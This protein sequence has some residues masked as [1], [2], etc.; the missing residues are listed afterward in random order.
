MSRGGEPEERRRDPDP[1]RREPLFAYA[2]KLAISS[3]FGTR[4]LRIDGVRDVAVEEADVV[5]HDLVEAAR[6]ADAAT[7]TA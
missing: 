1:E 3:P 6:A 5:E 4:V 2:T 7:E